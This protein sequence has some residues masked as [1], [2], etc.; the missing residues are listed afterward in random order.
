MM[1]S[2]MLR[3]IVDADIAVCGYYHHYLGRAV[4]KVPSQYRETK[5][6]QFLRLYGQGYLNMPWNKLYKK[7]LAGKFKEDLSLGEDLLFNLDY[8]RRGKEIAVVSEPLYHY[9][10]DNTGTSLSGRKRED[11]TELGKMLW[12]EALSFYEEL[13]G[14]RDTSGVINARL[15]QEVLDDIESL[16]FDTTR[17]RAEKLAV[18]QSCCQDAE[19]KEAGSN[20]ALKALDYKIIH[21]CM[22][23]NQVR[24]TYA[25]CVLRAWIVKIRKIL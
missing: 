13:T 12:K 4:E 18:I 11:K 24:I 1:V 7:A 23:R 3:G 16:P 20:V 10:Q 5:G 17:S 21:F 14:N 9:I 22:R 25:L 19:L 8:L 2:R 6:E 15:I